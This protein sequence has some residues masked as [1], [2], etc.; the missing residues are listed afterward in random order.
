MQ[1]GFHHHL[2]NKAVM[3]DT[4]MRIDEDDGKI[5][6]HIKDYWADENRQKRIKHY[7]IAKDKREALGKVCQE[8]VE[9]PFCFQG[10]RKKVI[11]AGGDVVD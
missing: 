1:D 6:Q 5:C 4:Y 9:K 7:W 10:P 3:R 8:D 11:L 2:R